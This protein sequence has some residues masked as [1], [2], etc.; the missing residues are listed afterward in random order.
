MVEQVIS[1]HSNRNLPSFSDRKIFVQRCVKLRERPPPQDISSSI[2]KLT[3]RRYR[4]S[5]WIKPTRRSTH[6]VPIRTDARVRIADKVRTLRS[7]QRL[8]IGIVEV[9]HW[10]KWEA[11]VNVGHSRD[12]PAI[13]ETPA[14][15]QI[16]NNVCHE[17]MP[18]IEIRWAPVS[19]A[20]EDI[21]SCGVSFT[22]S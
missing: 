10:A 18:D 2:A 14:A 19:L 5:I 3:G 20:I 6:A 12:L 1:F 15:R 13:Q 22:D 11:A 7:K 17:V 4:K 16:V 9:E 21:L 8:H